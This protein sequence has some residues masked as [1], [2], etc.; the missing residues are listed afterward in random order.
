MSKIKTK[1]LRFTPALNDGAT[2]YLVYVFNAGDAFDYDA[3]NYDVGMQIDQIDLTPMIPGEGNYDI[4]V[5]ARDASGNLS[6]EKAI[7]EDYPF[8]M[9]A[10]LAVLGGDV[11]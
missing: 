9:T 6:D 2:S 11:Y 4:Y 7:V 10:P 1:Y 3:L 8:D 5:V